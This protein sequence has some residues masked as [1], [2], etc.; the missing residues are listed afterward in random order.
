[1]GAMNPTSLSIVWNRSFR[2]LLARLSTTLRRL[3][4]LADANCEGTVPAGAAQAESRKAD[5]TVHRQH[6]QQSA[7][8]LDHEPHLWSNLRNNCTWPTA[9][10]FVDSS[11][12]TLPLV[13][14][15]YVLTHA[16]SATHQIPAAP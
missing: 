8:Q 6:M 10:G 4:G 3:A 14:A 7:S 12:P 13:A 5:G 9:C 2:P 11:N 15:T 1:L 16:V